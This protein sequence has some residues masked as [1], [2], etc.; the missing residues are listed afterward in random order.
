MFKIIKDVFKTVFDITS[1]LPFKHRWCM[2]NHWDEYGTRNVKL[3]SISS[4]ITCNYCRKEFLVVHQLVLDFDDKFRKMYIQHDVIGIDGFVKPEQR[5]FNVLE[6]KIKMGVEDSIE[7]LYS[8][9]D[10]VLRDSDFEVINEMLK[11]LII[12]ECDEEIKIAA[13]LITYPCKDKLKFRSVL[14]MDVYRILFL[15][16]VDVEHFEYLHSIK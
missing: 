11:K 8:A 14:Y 5:F 4:K 1:F 3:T 15:K 7:Y 2:H 12:L 13:L 10:K 16:D 6:D 9:F